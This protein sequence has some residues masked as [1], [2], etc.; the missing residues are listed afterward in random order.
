MDSL[1]TLRDFLRWGASR[2]AGAGLFYGHGTAGAADEA[3]VLL[4]HVLHL[5]LPLPVDFLDAALT[6]Q[7]R[8]AVA[9]L[10][11]RRIDERLPAPYLTGEAWFAGLRFAVDPRVL[12]PRSPIAELIENGFQPW[13]AEAEPGRILDIG[14]GSG[15]I[16]VACAL[17]FPDAQVDAVDVSAD[18]LEV[19]ATNVA[20]YGLEE[21]VRLLQSDLY[22][23]LAGQRY[24]LIVS[25]PPYVPDAEYATLPHEYRHEPRGALVSPEDGL[26]HPLRILRGAAQHLTEGGLLV[27]EVG[28]SWPALVERLP[29]VP[30]TWVELARGGEGVAVIGREELLT[31][32]F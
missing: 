1:R 9:A 5:D 29:E 24:D 26:E 22:A 8:A 17:A 2:F 23:A 4:A 25:N 10:F 30:F 32:E 18:A 11:A 28:A 6:A 31:V 21:R 19:A 7:E 20:R 14:T 16:A 12:I 15:C 3:A 27:L 13:L